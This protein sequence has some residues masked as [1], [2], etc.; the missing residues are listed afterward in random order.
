MIWKK[1]KVI[2]IIFFAG[3]MYAFGYSVA[4]TACD[5]RVTELEKKYA[6]DYASLLQK[7]IDSERTQKELRQRI[8]TNYLVELE[9]QKQSYETLLTDLHVNFKPSGVSNCSDDSGRVSRTD[10]PSPEL[11]CYT[12]AELRSKVERSLVIAR[13]A[14]E[15]AVKYNTLLKLYE[16]QNAELEKVK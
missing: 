16:T 12:R 13:K 7:K 5:L 15:L 8:E 14:D 3:F 9:R 11:V 2:V 10:K 6:S 4:E 1:I